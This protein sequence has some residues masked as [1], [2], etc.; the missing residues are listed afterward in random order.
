MDHY[1]DYSHIMFDATR[2]CASSEDVNC[3]SVLEGCNIN[4]DR[5][6]QVCDDSSWSLEFT[7]T[8]NGLDIVGDVVCSADAC[9][10][11]LCLD[12]RLNGSTDL[13]SK[14]KYNSETISSRASTPSL[15]R[16]AKHP[17]RWGCQRGT[18]SCRQKRGRQFS[19]RTSC[20]CG[21]G[22]GT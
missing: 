4:E 1:Y 10:A 5:T 13:A 9:P 3:F 18:L 20:G 8:G 12:W 2:M 14:W 7:F 19:G 17:S 6:R 16:R 21:R 22:I 11:D 15:S